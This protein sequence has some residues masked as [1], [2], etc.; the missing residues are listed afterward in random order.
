MIV[1]KTM[2]IIIT[3]K[4]MCKYFKHCIILA[5]LIKHLDVRSTPLASPLKAVM[6]V[7][8]GFIPF[9]RALVESDEDREAYNKE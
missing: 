5:R 2:L 7:F 4:M 9:Q 6:G 1:E 3:G 8:G